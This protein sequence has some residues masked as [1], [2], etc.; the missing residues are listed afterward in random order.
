VSKK[1]QRQVGTSLLQ[2]E[3]RLRG[4]SQ[5]YVA[6]QIG[7]TEL[8][9]LRWEGG[10]SKP[11]PY[12]RKQLCALLGKSEQALG[13]VSG[14]QWISSYE[15]L[16]KRI[17]DPLLPLPEV[18][19]L[20]G[21]DALLESLKLRL[22]QGTSVTVLG[23]LPGV[24]KTA[25]AVALAHDPALREHFRDGIL[26]AGLGPTPNSAGLLSRFGF[27]ITFHDLRHTGA[28]LLLEGGVPANVVQQRLGHT[29][30]ATTLR[31]YAHVTKRMKDQSAAT[32][33]NLFAEK[34]SASEAI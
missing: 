7:C 16:H 3:R 29:D 23:G 17:D 33:Q 14:D 20:V 22:C 2:A 10:K 1:V 9:V 18:T 11:G 8:T 28:T 21:R 27:D 12:H 5:A 6:E 4:W 31:T 30:I 24:G 25:L 26:W 13:L 32:L 19:G 15:E 34:N